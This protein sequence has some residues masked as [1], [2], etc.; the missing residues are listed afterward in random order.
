MKVENKG[1]LSFLSGVSILTSVLFSV[2]LA[3]MIIISG[4]IFITM[5][6]NPSSGSGL[7]NSIYGSTRGNWLG[8][9]LMDLSL[10]LTLVSS[11][12]IAFLMFKVIKNVQNNIYFSAKNLDYFKHVLQC[13]SILVV[14]NIFGSV[15]YNLFHYW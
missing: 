14:S 8:F 1:I 5:L 7:I 12:I 6:V 10:L 15:I 4:I 3:I 2:A 13:F 9:I 11:A